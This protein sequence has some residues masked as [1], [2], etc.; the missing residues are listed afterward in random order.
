MILG[1][2]TC[3]VGAVVMPS[4][5]VFDAGLSFGRCAAAATSE[6]PLLGWDVLVTG[7]V[8]GHALGCCAGAV[9]SSVPSGVES[10]LG[11]TGVAG[12]SSVVP[13]GSG[14]S[15]SGALVS[16]SLVGVGD[17]GSGSSFVGESASDGCA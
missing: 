7:L 5:F 1:A 16:S 11:A 15:A 6:A 17:T 10:V 4:P 2:L 14:C 12:V 3:D 8:G 13:A 9:A